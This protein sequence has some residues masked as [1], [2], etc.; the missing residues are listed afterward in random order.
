MYVVL[1]K[2]EYEELV[3]TPGKISLFI[4]SLENELRLKKDDIKV[5]E[6]IGDENIA[7]DLSH[8]YKG[9]VSVKSLFSKYC[10]GLINDSIK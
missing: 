6:E 7:N 3:Q 2:E 10:G 5:Y 9:M 4:D 1:S 8:E